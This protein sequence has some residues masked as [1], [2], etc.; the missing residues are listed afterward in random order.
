VPAPIFSI[1][2]ELKQLN[3]KYSPSAR[4]KCLYFFYIA[5]AVRYIWI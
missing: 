5:N 3:H 4:K 2:K 1:I